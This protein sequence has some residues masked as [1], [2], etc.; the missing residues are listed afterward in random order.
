MVENESLPQ[1]EFLVCGVWEIL[2]LQMLGG[3]VYSQLWFFGGKNSWEEG[4]G[5][6]NL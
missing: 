5:G 1:K 4:Y 3:E 6:F 2:R